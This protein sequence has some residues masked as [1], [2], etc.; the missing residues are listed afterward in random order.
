MTIQNR[1]TILFTAL[2]AFIILLLSISIYYFTA[3]NIADYFFHRL[4]VRSGIVVHMAI[5]ENKAFTQVYA[6]VKNTHLK[7]LPGEQHVFVE[8]PYTRSTVAGIDKRLLDEAVANGPVRYALNDRSYVI[9]YVSRAG[10]PFLIVSSAI[11]TDGMQELSGLRRIL[12]I[13][14]FGALILVFTAGRIFSYWVFKPVRRIIANVK[15][16]S[17]HNLHLRL[18]N[19]SSAD[20]IEALT[21][22]FND[23][24]NRLETT[25][26]LQNNFVSNASHEFRTPLTVIS[27]E[28]ELLLSGRGL[29]EEAR[30]ALETIHSEA[31]KLRLLTGGLLS[32]AQTG[33]DGRKQLWEKIRMDELLMSV[34]QAINEMIP[35]NSVKLDFSKLPLNEEHLWITGNPAL[36]KAAFANIVANACKYSNNGPV[37]IELY[38]ST[39]GLVVRITDHGIGIPESE[40]NQIFVPFFRASNTSNYKGYGI[41]LPLALNIIKMHDGLID[42]RSRVGEG[43]RIS[44]EILREKI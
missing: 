22:T 14:F 1:I 3:R 30:L 26:E 5:E 31:E 44:I 12:I 37:E 42:V 10:N 23:M 36:L 21:V 16:I 7:N 17:A 34:K 6:D 38:E 33:F 8:V 19:A 41:G 18:D 9:R 13:G 11:D 25:F 2:V 15:G 20:E 29:S 40:L 39:R 24:L 32:L 35:Q 28:A 4:E 43:T 27:G